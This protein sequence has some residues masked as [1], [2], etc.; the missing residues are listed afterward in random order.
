MERKSTYSWDEVVEFP[1]TDEYK[2]YPWSLL[3][4]WYYLLDY[5]AP[6][7]TDSD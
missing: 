5:L 3:A 1:G 4:V 7:K 2:M 6:D